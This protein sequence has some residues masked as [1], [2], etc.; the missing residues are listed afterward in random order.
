MSINTS[1][2]SIGSEDFLSI[3]TFNSDL[4]KEKTQNCNKLYISISSLLSYIVKDNSKKTNYKNTLKKQKKSI[5]TSKGI[6]SITLIDYIERIK[7]YMKIEDNTFILGIIYLDRFCK[8]SEIVLTEYNTHRLLFIS[9]L[10]AL[11]YQEDFY[12][13]NTFYAK[14]SGV[15]ISDLNK[16]EYEYVIQM[17]FNFYV[18]VCLFKK[19]KDFL[20]D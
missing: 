18:N 16:M 12:F 2:T 17:N 3:I 15:K 13:K 6:P 9:I 4:K 19:Y 7:K 20:N 10:I 1:S 14:I 8:K 5:F 11:K